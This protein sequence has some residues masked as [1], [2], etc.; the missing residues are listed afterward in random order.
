VNV[1]EPLKNHLSRFG[2]VVDAPTFGKFGLKGLKGL[3]GP[4]ALVAPALLIY[5]L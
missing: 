1:K 2:V 3:K 4:K 5:E